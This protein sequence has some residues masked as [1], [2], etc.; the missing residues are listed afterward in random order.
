M[1][2]PGLWKSWEGRVVDGKF[3]LRQWLGG[4]DHSAV[5]L[6]EL[7]GLPSSKAAIKLTACDGAEADRQISQWRAAGQ[8]SHPNLIRIYDAG[9]FRLG[10]TPLLYVV[11]EYAEEDLSQILPHRPLVPGEAADMLPPL[12]DALSYVHGKQFVHSR[13]KPSNVLAVGNQLKLSADQVVAADHRRTP[14][15]EGSRNPL[16]GA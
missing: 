14:T 3:P 9:R 7:P 5:F 13:I 1:S 4:S 16:R 12:L 6:T 11:M 2:T 15:R 8:L 10:S